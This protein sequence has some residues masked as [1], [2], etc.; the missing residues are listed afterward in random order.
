MALSPAAAI[1]RTA[2]G[3]IGNVISF[4]LFLS[5][6]PTFRKVVK[7]K[8]TREFSG[9]PYVVMLFNSLLW[10]YYGL[11]IAVQPNAI[12]VATINGVGCVLEIVYI[13]TFL[14]YA[15]SKE[16][17]K[18][19]ILLG[20]VLSLVALIVVLT[21]VMASRSKRIIIVGILCVVVNVAMYASP[22]TI[23]RKVIQAK[24]VK[25]MP[26][27][28]S[29]TYFLNGLIWSTYACIGL[30]KFLL[31][32]NGSGAFLGACQLII[33]AKYYGG[34]HPE[35]QKDKIKQGIHLGKGGQKVCGA[36]GDVENGATKHDLEITH[37]FSVE[38]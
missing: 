31:I 24:S 9:V 4:F 37:A 32:S 8:S 1:A 30:D 29:F 15:N 17:K 33:Y 14:F 18:M 3:I 22:L 23:M 25:Y 5:P 10:V 26:F 16:R 27:S 2:I 6:V 38:T 20:A 7:W 36:D 11:P 13:A 19:L 35:D 12:L 21:M 28:L 34:I